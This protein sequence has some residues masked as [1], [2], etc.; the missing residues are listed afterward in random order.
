MDRE[1]KKEHL[2]SLAQYQRQLWQQPRLQSLFFELTDQCNLRCRHC[3]SSCT[4][5]NRNFLPLNRIWGVLD[6]VA[7]KIDPSEIMVCLTGGEPL[8]HPAVYEVVWAAHSRGYFCGMT[9]NATLIDDRM[10]ETL[11]QS[12]LDTVSVSLDGLPETHDRFRNRSG[13]FDAA[14]K[15]IRCLRKYGLEAQVTTVV[16]P[17]N[18]GELE[19][20]HHL[21]LEENIYSWRLTN[22]DPIGRARMDTDILL[23]GEEL[24]QLYEFIREK[25]STTGPGMEITYGCSHFL[26]YDLEHEIRDFYFQCGAGTKVASIAANGDILACLDIERRPDLVQGNIYRDDFLQVWEYGFKPFRRDRSEKSDFC[27]GCEYRPVCLGDSAHTWDYDNNRPLYCATKQME[28]I[29]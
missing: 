4:A 14:L 27:S 20:L 16:Y 22:V 29:L 25:R 15:G 18:L 3:G 5:D 23:N 10:A 26:G 12:G 19:A 6:S 21:L 2:Q 13:A 8:L 28:G 7:L 24:R 11:V 17:E 1:T 9:T